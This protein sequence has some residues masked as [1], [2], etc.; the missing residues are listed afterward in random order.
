MAI[1][2]RVFT[3]AHALFFIF[4]GGG[5]LLTPHLVWDWLYPDGIQPS[6][7]GSGTSTDVSHITHRA[8]GLAILSMQVLLL[9]LAYLDEK[10]LYF[11][12]VFALAPYHVGMLVMTIMEEQTNLIIMHSCIL[13]LLFIM[14]V[15]TTDTFMIAGRRLNLQGLRQSIGLSGSTHNVSET[16]LKT[17]GRAGNGGVQSTVIQVGRRGDF[18]HIRS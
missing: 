8:Y 2:A 13:A 1:I 5:M 11:W 18:G 14:W 6:E 9:G 12:I 16:E 4:V 3:V 15:S 10:R 17:A 7:S